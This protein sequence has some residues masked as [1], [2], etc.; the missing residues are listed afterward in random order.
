M[1]LLPYVQIPWFSKTLTA[2]PPLA[3]LLT[4]LLARFFPTWFA[5]LCYAFPD[6]WW[7]FSA[8]SS[9]AGILYKG[10]SPFARERCTT[11]IQGFLWLQSWLEKSQLLYDQSSISSTV[12][13][14]FLVPFPML[15]TTFGL[16]DVESP[17]TGFSFLCFTLM[18]CGKLC[19]LSFFRSVFT[20]VS[21]LQQSVPIPPLSAALFAAESALSFS[22]ALE[23]PGTHRNVTKCPF[24][25]SSFAL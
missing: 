4:N 20:W 17:P 2:A 13:R 24:A 7:V 18:P 9:I 15:Y 14:T 6:L 1:Q 23:W 10:V 11:N 3:H 22:S 25:T 8:F 21:E 5:S 16:W 12:L 19:Q